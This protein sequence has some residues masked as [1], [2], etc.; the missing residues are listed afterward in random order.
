MQA[1]NNNKTNPWCRTLFDKPIVTQIVK[2]YPTF[3][4]EPECSSPCSQNSIIRFYSEP[5]EYISHLIP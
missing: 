3:F 2:K 5:V 4:I 1:Y